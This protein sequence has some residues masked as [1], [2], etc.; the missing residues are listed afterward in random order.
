MICLDR[1]CQARRN[2]GLKRFLVSLKG[3]E[4]RLKLG[5]RRLEVLI[6]N[7]TRR[8]AT[9]GAGDREAVIRAAGAGERE[10]AACL[11][12]PLAPLASNIFI[13]TVKSSPLP[14]APFHPAN[15]PGGVH[16]AFKNCR[17]SSISQAG[18]R[19]TFGR[20]PPVECVRQGG[21]LTNRVAVPVRATQ[22]KP[23]AKLVHRLNAPLC[24]LQKFREK[25]AHG[26]KK[27]HE[28]PCSI[29]KRRSV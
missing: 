29:A 26:A 19:R 8:N 22:P 24:A 15:P 23:Q 28:G 14:V 11:Y 16:A 27:Q 3:L 4:I 25:K 20:A 17:P 12:A 7:A 2:L 9:G 10:S 1:G 21:P 13:G 5:A 6:G 18:V